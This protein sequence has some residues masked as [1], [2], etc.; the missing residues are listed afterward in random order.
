VVCRL[1]CARHRPYSSCLVTLLLHMCY[2]ATQ[3]KHAWHHCTSCML[4][5]QWCHNS[6]FSHVSVMGATWWWDAWMIRIFIS[7]CWFMLTSNHWWSADAV[8]LSLLR[9]KAAKH[10][11]KASFLCIIILPFCLHNMRIA[12]ACA[13]S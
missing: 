2:P 3:Y 8:H 9:K 13:L 1:G 11:C 5:L 7:Y 12:L 10:K 4:H 6:A